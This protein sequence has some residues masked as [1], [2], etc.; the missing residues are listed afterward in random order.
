MFREERHHSIDILFVIS[1]FAVFA[2]SVVMLTGTGARVYERIVN[3]MEINHNERTTF[4]YLVNKIRQS[5]EEGKISVGKFAGID[6]LIITEEI[7]NVNFCTYLYYYDGNLKEL[8][9]RQ[10]QDM[11]P[12]YGTD[13]LALDSF[14]VEQKSDSLYE[15]FFNA[16]GNDTEK[17]F[18][19][20]RSDAQ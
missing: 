4:S 11:D 19:H 8:F 2:L 14:Y 17:L 9:I 12:K 6:S 13:I 15:L 7:D 10:A 18:V 16:K 1:L 3:N 20:V 5:D